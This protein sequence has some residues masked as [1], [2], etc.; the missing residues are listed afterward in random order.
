M[1]SQNQE[2][3]GILTKFAESG[4]DVIDGPSRAWLTNPGDPQIQGDL[5][6]AIREADASCGNCGCDFDPLYKRA[7]V[8][9]EA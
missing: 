9:L 2:F 1:L 3:I 8:L 4:W 6:T 5:V 7:L